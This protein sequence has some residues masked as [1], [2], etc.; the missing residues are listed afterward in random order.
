VL[1]INNNVAAKNMQPGTNSDT[2]LNFAHGTIYRIL[3]P[4]GFLSVLVLALVYVLDLLKVF[5]KTVTY[6]FKY[7]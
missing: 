4:K 5:I 2:L 7:H 6:S 1:G 3:L